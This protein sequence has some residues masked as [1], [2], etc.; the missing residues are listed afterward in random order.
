MTVRLTDVMVCVR[1]AMNSSFLCVDLYIQLRL[2]GV[3]PCSE[4]IVSS[5]ILY[6]TSIHI[7]Y[8]NRFST[9]ML[10]QVN[11]IRN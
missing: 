2:S 10:V 1:H 6:D 5:V 3:V 8:I 7:V 11:L 4:L 9:L